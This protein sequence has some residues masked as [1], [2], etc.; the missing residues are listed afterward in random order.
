M[1]NQESDSNA[2]SRH[3]L[4]YTAILVTIIIVAAIAGYGVVITHQPSGPSTISTVV[5]GTSPSLELYLADNASTLKVGQKLNVV[6]SLNNTLATANSVAASKNWLFGGV[7]VALWPTCYFD[8]PAYAV[9]LRGNYTLQGLQSA[10]NVTFSVRCM[11]AVSVDHVIFQPSSSHANLTGIYDV[12][13]ANQT[14]GP[15]SLSLN[16]TTSGFWDLVNN[17]RQLNPPIIG[18]QYP[19]EPPIATPFTP[20]IYTVAVADEWGQA[21]VLHFT[22]TNR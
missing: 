19:P 11:E 9:V 20:G 3:R 1:L 6:V 5:S 7:P 12:S 2:R 10:A 8:T 17:S 22:V 21:A 4:R 13:G 16:F 15:F 14:L 18:Q